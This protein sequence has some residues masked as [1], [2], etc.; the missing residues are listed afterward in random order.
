MKITDYKIECVEFK[1][2]PNVGGKKKDYKF[3]VIHYDASSAL[4]GLNWMLDDKSDVSAELWIGRDARLVQLVPFNMTAWH[5]GKSEFRQVEGLNSYAIG[6][7]L[8]NTGGQ[9]YTDTQ[10]DKLGEVAKLLVD[11]Y[12]LEIIG[13]EDCSPQ[14]KS[15]PSGSKVNM[16]DWKR[17]FNDCEIPTPKLTTIS[18]LNIRRGQ[19]TQYPVVLTLKKGTEVFELNRVGEWS[20]IQVK[21]TLQ[22]GWINNRFLK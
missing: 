19:G 22:S 18:D 10:M 16:F 21:G 17:L 1:P 11:T 7:E 20:K 8:Q 12:G 13:H 3:L 15:D 5:A 2:S 6:I 14:R 4:Q 9:A